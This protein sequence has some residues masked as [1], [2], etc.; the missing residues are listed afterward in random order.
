[1]IHDAL[2]DV[3]LHLDSRCRQARIGAGRGLIRC[4]L[5][6]VSS[7]CRDEDLYTPQASLDQ[8]DGEQF[9][10]PTLGCDSWCHL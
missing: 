2:L 10:T 9:C 5:P 1:M 3:D 6:V 4:P 8:E 7:A